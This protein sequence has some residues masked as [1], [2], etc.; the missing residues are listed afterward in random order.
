VIAEVLV[1]IVRVDVAV[2]PKGGITDVGLRPA[3]TPVG[4]PETERPTVPVKPFKEVTFIVE[5]LKP[6]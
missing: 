6:L 4:A 1:E 5:V 3:V 2:P